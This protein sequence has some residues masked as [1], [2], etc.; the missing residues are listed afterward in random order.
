M[1]KPEALDLLMGAYFH[2]DW[3]LDHADEWAVLAAFEQDEP[4]LAQRLPAEIDRVLAKL[5]TESDLEHYFVRVL[6]ADFNAAHD[7]GTYRGW[8]TQI[9]ERVRA[10][11]G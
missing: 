9:A 3:T 6:G 5:Q 1:E 4:A 7:G 2:Q 11:T 8:L 10:A